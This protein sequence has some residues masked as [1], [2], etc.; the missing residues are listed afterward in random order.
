MTLQEFQDPA[1]IRHFQSICDACQELI[2]S[3]HTP[4]ELKFYT[5][6]YLHALRKARSIPL[7]DQETLEKLVERWVLD[8]SSFIGPDGDMNNLYHPKQK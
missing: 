6:G 3:F 2:N 8:P 1:S 4:T 7:K 5:D